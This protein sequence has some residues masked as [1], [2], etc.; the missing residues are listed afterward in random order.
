M[1]NWKTLDSLSFSAR[2]NLVNYLVNMQMW[3]QGLADEDNADNVVPALLKTTYIVALVV[4]FSEHKRP[5]NP[6]STKT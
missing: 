3:V 1:L 5:H 4:F 2:Y 6:R